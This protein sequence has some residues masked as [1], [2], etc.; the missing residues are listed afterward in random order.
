MRNQMGKYVR[1][2]ALF[3]DSHGAEADSLRGMLAA[4]DRPGLQ[5]LAHT[6]KG[7][8]GNI[9]AAGVVVAAGE[10]LAATRQEADRAEIGRCTASLAD[11]LSPLIEGIRGVLAVVGEGAAAVDR[12]RAPAVLGR[13]RELLEAGDIAAND[14]ARAEE[15]LL[16]AVLG[17]AGTELLGRIAG[18]DYEGA[19]AVWP[20]DGAE[21]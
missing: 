15:Q 5:R 2:L 20:A 9:G 8:A 16:C 4:D 1:L 3:V 14:L 12:T 7:S 19:L 17:A 10:L 6:L 11:E 21:A 13:L 18:F